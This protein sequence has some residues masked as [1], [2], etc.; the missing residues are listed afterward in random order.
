MLGHSTSLVMTCWVLRSFLGRPIPQRSRELERHAPRVLDHALQV[1]HPE[2]LADELLDADALAAIVQDL[3]TSA[4]VVI[5]QS[6][7]R[8]TLVGISSRVHINRRWL[9]VW[10]AKIFQW[11]H[12]RRPCTDFQA[13]PRKRHRATDAAGGTQDPV[14]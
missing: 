7:V 3:H 11:Q 13:R 5:T 8:A 6:N 4:V 12:R 14:L 9:A 2:G 10:V 1:L